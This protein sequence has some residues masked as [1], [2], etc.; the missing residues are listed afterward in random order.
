MRVGFVG[1]GSI[2]RPMLERTVA[3]GHEVR[4]F[5]RRPEVVADV[6]ATGAAPASSVAALGAASD[7]VVVCVFSD[8]QVREVCDGEGGLL[9]H[10]SEG[11]AV[12]VHSTCAPDTVR[13]LAEAG[14]ARGVAVL[15]APFSGRVEDAVAGAITLLAA[16]PAA[17]LARVRPV[18][19]A[20]CDPILHVGEVGDG[21]RVKLV[22]NALFAASLALAG[23]AERLAEDLGLD[24]RVTLE[25][26]AAC[27]GDSFAVRSGLA[28]GSA[29]FLRAA[30]G[31]Y[32]DKD[33]ATAA[34]LATAAGTELGLLGLAAGAPGASADLG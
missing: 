27:S 18:L 16:G 21:Q 29:R 30:A 6:A 34:A 13:R 26:V 9:A 5:A 24:P 19:E 28:A 7:V 17:L 8:D 1:V 20:Y 12:V 31:R 15:D 32:I 4:F 11:G 3:A 33:V 10:V 23:D 2:G 14:A 22:N 25:A